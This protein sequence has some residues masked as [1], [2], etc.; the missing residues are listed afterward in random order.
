MGGIKNLI[1]NSAGFRT[2]S[3]VFTTI[4][5]GVLCGAF[6]TEITVN[7]KLDWS[8]NTLKHARFFWGLCIY[9]VLYLLYSTYF[10][11]SEKNILKYRDLEFCLA[12]VTKAGLQH[13][14]DRWNQDVKDGKPVTDL[15]DVQEALRKLTGKL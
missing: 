12:Y 4:I 9:I 8:W 3:F 13:I 2:L 11:N 7:G 14:S 5:S 15:F 10:Y 6:I 1:E